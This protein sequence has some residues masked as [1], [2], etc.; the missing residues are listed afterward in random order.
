MQL[1]DPGAMGSE[2]ER[3]TRASGL[4]GGGMGAVSLKRHRSGINLAFADG[5]AQNLAVP[6]WWKLH[7][8]YVFQPR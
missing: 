4:G 5:H 1:N 7:W 3:K 6:E 8:S 2:I